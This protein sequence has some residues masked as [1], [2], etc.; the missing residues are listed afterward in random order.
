M[1]RV[2]VKVAEVFGRSRRRVS[3][4]RLRVRANLAELQDIAESVGGWGQVVRGLPRGAWRLIR[5][6][7]WGQL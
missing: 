2:R 1:L 4:A 5:R 3:W 7:S 6:A